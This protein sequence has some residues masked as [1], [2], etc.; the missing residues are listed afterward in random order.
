MLGRRLPIHLATQTL[1]FIPQLLATS[2]SVVCLGRPPHWPGQQQMRV[3]APFP[4]AK[5]KLQRWQLTLSSP[6]PP[7]PNQ[8]GDNNEEN[9]T[10]GFRKDIIEFALL[11]ALAD[12]CMFQKH[13]ALARG[14]TGPRQ[15]F[16]DGAVG[17]CRRT[18]VLH[19]RLCL[20]PLPRSRDQSLW[21][22]AVGKSYPT[23]ATY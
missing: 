3:K 13:G 12:L 21:R 7:I 8:R 4:L 14:V 9:P 6:W 2:M 18:L 16:H 23:S 5:L 19:M 20:G 22:T 1:G 11:F 15:G 17:R 10:V